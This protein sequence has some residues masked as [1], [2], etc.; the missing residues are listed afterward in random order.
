[1]A[2]T[3]D[4]VAAKWQRNLTAS[5][6]TIKAGV[7]AVTVAPGELAA[8]KKESWVNRLAD[9]AVQDK[10]ERNVRAVSLSDW[11]DKMSTKGVA[12]IADGAKGAVPKVTRFMEQLLPVAARVKAACAAMPKGTLEEGIARARK[13][14]E[15]MHEFQF[16]K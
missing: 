9:A 15:M 11:K 7:D 6:V 12:R 2:K 5:I 1:M 14:I 13:A 8:K 3:A 10:W 4:E 16:K